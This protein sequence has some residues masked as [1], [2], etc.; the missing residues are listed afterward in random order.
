MSEREKLV[1]TAQSYIGCKESDGSHK[2]IINIYNGHR[3][4]ARG[5]AVKYTDEWC[6]TFV[7]AMAIKCGL[8]AIMPTECGCDKMIELYKKLGAWQENDAHKPQ[9][10]DVIFYDW[11]DV[12]GGVGEN[13]GSSDHVGIV[14]KVSGNTITVIEG[15][16]RTAVGRRTLKVNGR[17]IRGY[18]VPKFKEEKD[19]GKAA[20]TAK[21]EPAKSYDKTLAG[22]YTATTSLNMRTG[23]GTAKEKILT[24]PRGAAVINYGYYSKDSSGTKWLYVAYNDVT[25]FCSS[26]YLKK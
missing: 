17:Y 24:I 21:P 11:Q 2:P 9:P 20:S 25:G 10:G 19:S 7:S 4:L 6:A 3:P 5:Y 18:G 1:K 14:E 12:P 8:T 15:N 23:A 13:R 22:V 16:I 26:K